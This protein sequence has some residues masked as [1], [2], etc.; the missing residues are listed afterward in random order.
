MTA[1]PHL[2]KINLYECDLGAQGCM[3]VVCALKDRDGMHVCLGGNGVTIG[4]AEG[5]ALYSMPGISVLL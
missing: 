3:A 4:S 2:H 5:N 1:L